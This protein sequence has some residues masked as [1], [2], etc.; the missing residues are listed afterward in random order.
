[1]L[2]Q[3][4]PLVFLPMLARFE[5]VALLILRVL[6]GVFL[7]WGVWDNIASAARMQEFVAFLANRGC[8][9]PTLAAPLSVYTQFI[10]GALLLIGFLTRWAGLVLAFN[11][12]VAVILTWSSSD[13]RMLFTPLVLIAVSL[14]VA[15]RGAGRLGLDASLERRR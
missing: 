10:A 11:F 5:D 7:I 8:P 15:A 12:L 3:P 6:V 9:L 14:L 1:M 13:F 4:N 2:R